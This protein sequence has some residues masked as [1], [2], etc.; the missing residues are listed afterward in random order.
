MSFNNSEKANINYELYLCTDRGLMT[1]DTIEQSVEQG[2]LG[3]VSFVQL[4]EKDCSS[5]EFFDLACRVK[6]ITDRFK[7]PFVIN[8]RVDI[9]LVCGADGVHLGQS[10]LPCSEVRKAVGDDFIIGVSCSEIS[11]AIKAEKDGADYIG[12]GAMYSTQTKTDAKSVSLEKLKEIRNAV[13]IPIVV[14]GGINM[15]TADDFA[16]TGIDG[17]A[18]VSAVV[19]Q[20]DIK[21]AAENM[22]NKFRSLNI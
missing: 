13:S 20:K 15:D 5:R 7:V 12:V 4:R 14:I 9:A 2:I 17:F 19:S 18:V 6:E 22:K 16:G 11:Q 10:D 3:G 1:S 8:D 21:K